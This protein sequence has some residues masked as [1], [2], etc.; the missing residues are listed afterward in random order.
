M[1]ALKASYAKYEDFFYELAY[2]VSQFSGVTPAS[3]TA[4]SLTRDNIEIIK[5]NNLILSDAGKIT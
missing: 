4:N 1:L 2:F 3:I 5:L